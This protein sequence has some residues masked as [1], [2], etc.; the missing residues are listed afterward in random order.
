MSAKVKDVMTRKVVAV[1]TGASSREIAATLRDRHQITQDVILGRFLTDP[2]AFTV[3]VKDGIVTLEGHP[4]TTALGHEIVAAVRHLESVVAV[5]DRP[6]YPAPAEY[7]PLSG[8][9]F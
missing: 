6:S 8:P 1:H 2:T 9:L 3:I 7:V 5:R 4:E